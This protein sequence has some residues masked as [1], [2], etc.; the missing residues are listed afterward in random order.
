[1]RNYFSYG[2]KLYMKSVT[3]KQ[4]TKPTNPTKKIE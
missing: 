2:T 1:M 3:E 4:T